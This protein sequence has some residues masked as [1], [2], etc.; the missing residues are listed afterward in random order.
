M[1]EAFLVWWGQWGG[2]VLGALGTLMGL[3]VWIAR[4]EGKQLADLVVT[5]LLNLSAQGMD[6]VTEAQVKEVAGKVYDFARDYAGPGWLRVIPWRLFV[7]REMLQGWAWKGWLNVH[8]WYDSN[9]A[10]RV[11]ASVK[12]TVP[13][14]P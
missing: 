4:G 11:T 13:G 10:T 7:T 14:I 12:D 8:A 6:T 3:W 1:M 5:L 9:L 2:L